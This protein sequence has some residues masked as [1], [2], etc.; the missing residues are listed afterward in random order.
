MKLSALTEGNRRP[1]ERLQKI[2]SRR[3]I[4]HGFH[5]IIEDFKN[6]ALQEIAI[7]DDE[8]ECLFHTFVNPDA[9]IKE[10]SAEKSAYFTKDR[11]H[12]STLIA[13]KHKET[14]MR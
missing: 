4:E 10:S 12:H 1:R 8:M 11:L 5:S 3:K 14:T 6:E 13:P 9:K 2:A 7:S